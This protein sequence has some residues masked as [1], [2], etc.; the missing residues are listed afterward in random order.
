MDTKK[1]LRC[2][3]RASIYRY[4]DK[5]ILCSIAGNTEYGEPLLLGTDISDDKL[6]LALCDQ[7]LQYKAKEDR[8]C[9]KSSLSNWRAFKASGAKSVRSFE[10]NAMF[11]YVRTI[12]TAINIEAAPR[13]ANEQ[14]LVALC[15]ISNGRNH[16]E[17]GATVR[18]AIRAAE[19]LRDA[20]ML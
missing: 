8:D 10:E 1:R 19:V 3:L 20:G 6:G 7:L 2:E 16:A 12:N 17:V 9:P 18:K 15:S 13:V 4:K 11:V 14:E 5:F